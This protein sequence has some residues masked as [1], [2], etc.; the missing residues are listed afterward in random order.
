VPAVPAAD[1]HDAAVPTLIDLGGFALY[2]YPADAALREHLGRVPA[3]AREK[4]GELMMG[5]R[6]Q[7]HNLHRRRTRSSFTVRT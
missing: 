4:P 5:W 7:T 6:R 3:V 1:E 2:D